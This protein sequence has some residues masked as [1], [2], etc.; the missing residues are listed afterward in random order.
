MCSQSDGRIRIIPEHQVNRSRYGEQAVHHLVGAS[1]IILAKCHTGDPQRRAEHSRMLRMQHA[2][3]PLVA[4]WDEQA[5]V[6]FL[7]EFLLGE[8]AD[9]HVASMPPREGFRWLLP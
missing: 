4:A 5:D 9:T 2:R 1:E 6:S 3:A 7:G 8:I